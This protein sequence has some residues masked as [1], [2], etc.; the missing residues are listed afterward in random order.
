[1]PNAALRIFPET[2]RSIDSATFTGSYQTLGTVLSFPSRVLKI[3]N[4]SNT[5]ITLS[6]DGV[7]DH[8][9]IP[10]GSFILL[11]FTANAV[12]DST[13]VA[14]AGT[15]FYVKGSV[16]TGGVYLSSYFAR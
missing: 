13:L 2:L 15:Q 8:E 1:M 9:F 16:G 14:V 4:D 6:W 3:T 5:D 11:D 7:N 12:S 10:A